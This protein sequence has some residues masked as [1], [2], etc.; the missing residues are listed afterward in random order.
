MDDELRGALHVARPAK[1]AAYG[2][3]LLRSRLIGCLSTAVA[4]TPRARFATRIRSSS[5]MSDLG[6]DTEVVQAERTFKNIIIIS[7]V[8]QNGTSACIYL[9]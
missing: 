2:R 5:N 8:A 1:V 7:K 6:G 3:R 4:R 9:M